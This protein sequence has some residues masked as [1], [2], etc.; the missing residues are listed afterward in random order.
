LP[1][2]NATGQ[3]KKVIVTGLLIPAGKPEPPRFQD[4]DI[5]K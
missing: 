2:G 5:L 1:G 4:P 3:S